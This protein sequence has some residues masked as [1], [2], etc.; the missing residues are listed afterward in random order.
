MCNT[1]RT[2]GHSEKLVSELDVE[3]DTCKP[4]IMDMDA[5][6]EVKN[7][8]LRAAVLTLD[9]YLLHLR[10]LRD[11][12]LQVFQELEELLGALGTEVQNL[13]LV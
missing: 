1:R 9:A 7:Q 13:L 4:N 3:E 12:L 5:A 2:Q 6:D 11:G 8:T 10:H